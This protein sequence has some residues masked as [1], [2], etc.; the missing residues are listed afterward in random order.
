M[1][2][3]GKKTD[4][5]VEDFNVTGDIIKW[6]GTVIKIANIS[7]ITKQK[8]E[9]PIF[10]KLS[11][12]LIF[13]GICTF[14][15]N[16][17]IACVCLLAGIFWIISWSMQ[18]EEIEKKTILTLSMNSGTQIPILFHDELFLNKVLKVLEEVMKRGDIGAQNISISVNNCDIGGNAKFLS[19]IGIR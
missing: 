5:N 19:D 7:Y 9:I 14:S 8:L 6:Q 1:N 4:W 16:M 3:D 12:L 18:K 10:P 13:L 2:L 15:F 17:L 11:L